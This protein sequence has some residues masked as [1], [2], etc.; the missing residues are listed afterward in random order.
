MSI[1]WPSTCE[2]QMWTI[3]VRSGGAC[4]FTKLLKNDAS[5]I[6]MSKI[7]QG[8]LL[9]PLGILVTLGAY[10]SSGVPN[11]GIRCSKKNNKSLIKVLG[12]RTKKDFHKSCPNWMS[13]ETLFWHICAMNFRIWVQVQFCGYVI[14]VKSTKHCYAINENQKFRKAFYFHSKSLFFKYHRYFD[15]TDWHS[16]SNSDIK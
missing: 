5:F 1:Y 8:S 14:S 7:G 15:C 13:S 10:A 11:K 6:T 16:S 2:W 12:I 9:L 4:W 3:T